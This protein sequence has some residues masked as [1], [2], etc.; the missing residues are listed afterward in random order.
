LGLG[1]VAV[2]TWLSK[3]RFFFMAVTLTLLGI[4]FYKTYS[5]RC[6]ASR[7]NKIM[8]WVIAG[9]IISLTLYSLFRKSL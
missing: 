9:I 6:H 7:L 1:S 8:L 2:G 4:S 3:Y 5:G